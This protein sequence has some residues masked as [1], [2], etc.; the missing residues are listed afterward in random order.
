MGQVVVLN[1]E[2]QMQE[3]ASARILQERYDSVMMPWDR[4]AP[5]PVLGQSYDSYRRKTLIK[6]KQLLPDNHRL[7][8]VQVNQMDDSVLAVFEPQIM[9]ACRAAAYDVDTVPR[10]PGADGRVQFRRVTECDQNGMT[11]VKFIGPRSFI[12]DFKAPTRRVKSFMHTPHL[13]PQ[14]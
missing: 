6:M 10:E 9:S 11:L 8:K 5:E 2:Q 14:R 13:M 7:R 4:R 12:E 3:Q 1:H